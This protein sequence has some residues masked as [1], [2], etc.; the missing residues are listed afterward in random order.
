M[1]ERAVEDRK[2]RELNTAKVA[3]EIGEVADEELIERTRRGDRRAF[4]ELWRR[5]YR[6]GITVA[7]S[8]TTLDADDLVSESFARIYKRTL[9]GGG[10]RGAFRPYLYTTIRNLASTWGTQR[11]KHVNVDELDDFEPTESA[12]EPVARSLDRT[13]TVQAYRSLPA[14]WQT[15]LWY[16]EVEGLD[17]HEVAPI[18]GMSANSVAALSYR[19]REGLRKAWLQAHVS[20]ATA[21]GTCAW[22]LERVGEHARRSLTERETQKLQ[23]H[24]AVCPKCSIVSE[25][26]DDIGARL[27]MVM[28]PLLLGGVVGGTLLAAA[29]SSGGAAVA[30]SAA[31]AGAGTAAAASAIPALPASIGAGTAAAATSSATIATIAASTIV[32]AAAGVGAVGLVQSNQHSTP[33]AESSTSRAGALADPLGIDAK[34]SK[35]TPTTDPTALP[36]VV[37][38]AATSVPVVPPA[39]TT[40]TPTTPTTSTTTDA[41]T[42]P[43]PSSAP[44]DASGSTSTKTTDASD[45]VKDTTKNTTT[46]A[47][48]AAADSAGTKVTKVVTGTT[49]AVDKV[50]TSTTSTVGK[51]VSG[52]TDTVDKVVDTVLPPGTGVTG[53]LNSTVDGVTTGLNGTVGTLTGTV[54]NTVGA[55]T[56]LVGGL[57]GGLLGGH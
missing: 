26:V 46:A 13:L 47:A 2:T 45:T 40:D 16:T 4:A 6:S 49:D 51:V 35:T 52:T 15:V 56:G 7:R 48:A 37:D 53:T 27:A 31:S 43:S 5:H 9:D 18:L 22:V 54:D 32:V 41:P 30:A 28:I 24:L 14:R 1:R 20:D 12:E 34:S 23:S 39:T 38:P 10:P 11:A 44:S 17:P 42:D 3:A 21:S 29:T 19:A 50:V 8:F 36:T 33:S 25:E 55:T 57:V